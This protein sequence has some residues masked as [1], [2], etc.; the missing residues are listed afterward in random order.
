M[1]RMRNFS[2]FF[3]SSQVQ[4]EQRKASKVPKFSKKNGKRG[5]GKKEKKGKS[6]KPSTDGRVP[7][8]AAAQIELRGVADKRY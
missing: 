5:R 8:I 6:E 7:V 1:S 4:I 2:F 3:N